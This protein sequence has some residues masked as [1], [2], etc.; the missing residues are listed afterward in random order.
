MTNKGVPCRRDCENREPGCHARCA[1]YIS[2]SEQHEK[3]KALR[4][5]E[6]YEASCYYKHRDARMYKLQKSKKDKHA[7]YHG[8]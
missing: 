4:H 2:W 8:K 7:K 5:D 6:G 3:E 1:A